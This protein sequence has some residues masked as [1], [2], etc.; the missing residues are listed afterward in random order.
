VSI[1]NRPPSSA[2]P[3]PHRNVLVPDTCLRLLVDLAYRD[4]FA[5]VLG[6]CGALPGKPCPIKRSLAAARRGR[7]LTGSDHESA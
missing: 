6:C 7:Q 2:T 5:L 1:Q 3:T 4:D